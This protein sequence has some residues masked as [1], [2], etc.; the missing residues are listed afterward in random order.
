MDIFFSDPTEIPLPP[1]E[2][3]IRD[4]QA[5][6]W[7]DGQKVKVYLE[8]DPFQKRPSAELEVIH[9]DG[10]KIASADVIESMTRKIE[11]NIH[12][13]GELAS[14][15]YR[16]NALLYYA[17]LPGSEDGDD[18]EKLIERKIVDERSISFLLI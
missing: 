6:L 8:V 5:K 12:L 16:L 17:D 7:S 3:R 18:T 2:V 15:E 14:G 1:E 9:P 10:Y 13:R 4:L 11:L